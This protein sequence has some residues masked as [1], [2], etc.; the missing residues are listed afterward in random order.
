MAHEAV[1]AISRSFLSDVTDVKLPTDVKELFENGLEVYECNDEPNGTAGFTSVILKYG[2]ELRY[3]ELSVTEA[4][5]LRRVLSM[6]PPVRKLFL[7]QI[8]LCPFKVAFHNQETCPSLKEVHIDFVEC[9]GKALSV[10]RCGMFRSLHSLHLCSV[11]SGSAFA[12]DIASYVRQNR[13]LRELSLCT[14]CGGDEGVATLMQA[15]AGNDTLKRF[16]LADMELSSDTLTGF[17]N[18]LVFNSALEMVNL[19]DVCSVEKDKVLSLLGQELYAGVFKRLKIQW[20]EELLPELTALLS[21]EG[22]CPELSVSVTPSACEAVLREFFGALAADKTLRVLRFL[23]NEDTFEAFADG[24]VSGLRRTTTLRAVNIGM[25]VDSA[26]ARQLIDLLDALKENRSVA[27]FAIST[28]VV[29]PEI[30][31]SLSELLAVNNTLNDVAI[32]NYCEILPGEVETIVKGSKTNY[33]L[34]SFVVYS[35]CNDCEGVRE[36]AAILQ[37]NNRL[38]N[39]A[40]EFVI[41]G[42]DAADEIGVDALRKVHSSDALV[43]MVQRLTGR[44]RE[45]ALEDIQAALA[46][47]PS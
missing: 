18:M 46:S 43:E 13:S 19:T 39:K 42:A 15:L 14:S 12:E 33:T 3:R 44:T 38:K 36:M 5:V 8:S 16:S 11:N 26:K 20:P 47:L 10:S 25:C 45:E 41:L 2:A 28:E 35:E 6:G 37:R 17:A 21:V 1:M 32:F 34:T 29:T 4:S 30:A 7:Q 22:C 27:K 40:A 24:I 23:S 9:E 31:T